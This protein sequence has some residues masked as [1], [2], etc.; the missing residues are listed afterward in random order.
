MLFWLRGLSTLKMMLLVTTVSTVIAGSTGF[1]AGKRWV[2]GDLYDQMVT[3]YD[4]NIETL[5]DRWQ[6]AA[7]SAQ[8]QVEDWNL[9]NTSDNELLSRLLNGQSDIRRQ[10]NEFEKD[11]LVINDFGACQLSDAAVRLLIDA[12][13]AANSRVPR[14]STGES[15]QD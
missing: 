7:D 4:E 1:I 15:G 6:D 10:F 11:M 12:G 9:Q 2:K 5:N 8:I 13:A 14:N 3:Q